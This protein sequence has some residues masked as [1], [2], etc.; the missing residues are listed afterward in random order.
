M[1][2]KQVFPYQFLRLLLNLS[3]SHLPNISPK[4][5]PDPGGTGQGQEWRGSQGCSWDPQGSLTWMDVLHV[6][7]R[8]GQKVGSY[9]SNKR[10]IACFGTKLATESGP[11]GKPNSITDSR[12]M[13]PAQ[14]EK[15]SKPRTFPL[16]PSVL[17]KGP[18]W[19]D[20]PVIFWAFPRIPNGQLLYYFI[21]LSALVGQP[22]PS[23]FKRFSSLRGLW[24]QLCFTFL[25]GKAKAGQGATRWDRHMCH[26][27]KEKSK[28]EFSKATGPCR[29]ERL[30]LLPLIPLILWA[31]STTSWKLAEQ[32]PRKECAGSTV[33]DSKG[34][35]WVAWAQAAR[36]T[37]ILPKTSGSH[38][39]G[40]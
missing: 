9:F 27:W 5:K 6:C 35:H 11:L 15:P 12:L 37:P 38:Q 4:S 24:P 13:R 17:Q 20:L 28:L 18:A 25:C 29:P 10:T 31:Q 14:K 3:F 21:P 26:T 39:P 7:K 16:Q 22:F 34:K 30:Q 32:L 19:S 1:W 36:E 23:G 40:L 8:R 33:E 2:T